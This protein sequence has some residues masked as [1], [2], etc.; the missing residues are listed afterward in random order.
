MSGSDPGTIDVRVHVDESEDPPQSENLNREAIIE[1]ARSVL[2]EEGRSR[3]ELDIVF[4]G[5]GRISELNETWL[6]REGPTDVIAFDLSEDP[7]RTDDVEGE[8][9]IDIAQAERQAPEFG[10]TLDEEVRRLVIHGI[11]HLVGYD[12]IHS[13]EEAKRMTERQEYYV[14]EW[15]KPVLEG[16]Q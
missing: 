10:A 16:A 9:Y 13:P 7:D 4:C 5:D 11:L 14:V 15:N 8:L 2:E 3:G 6:G 1:L 12:D